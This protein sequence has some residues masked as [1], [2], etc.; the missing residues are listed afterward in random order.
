ML[1][2]LFSLEYSNIKLD[3][4]TGMYTFLSGSLE[5]E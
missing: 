5:D 4:E 3:S 1:G 2:G